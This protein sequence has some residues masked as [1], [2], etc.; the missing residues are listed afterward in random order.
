M[1]RLL[2]YIIAVFLFWPLGVFSQSVEL[3]PITVVKKTFH[4][5]DYFSQDI[6]ENIPFFSPEEI[7]DYSS[8]IELKKRSLFGIQQDVSVRGSIFEDTSVYLGDIEINDPQT[9]HFNLE[10]P[11]TS[12]DLEEIGILKNSQKIKFV[13]KKP[14]Q[15]GGIV[16][17]SFGQH[18]LWEEGLSLNFPLKDINNRFS[19]EHKTSSGGRQDTDF[20]IYNFSFHSLLEKPDKE[21]EFLFGATER[22]FGADAFYVA[23]RPHEEEHVTQRFFSLR[24]GL[25]VNAFK[26][27]NT[28]YFRRHSD[29]YILDRHDPAYYTNY[30]TTYVYG[31]QSSFDFYNDLFLSFDLEREKI[32]STNLNKHRRLRKGASIGIKDKK[33]QDLI[34][35]FEAGLNY[36][37]SWEYLEDIHLGA[38][39]CLTDDLKLR[40]SFDRIWRAPSFTELYYN[41]NTYNI[42]TQDLDI[43]KSNNFEW[44]A[45]FSPVDDC[46]LA[47][48]FFL[49]EQFDTIDWVKDN[50]SDPWRT[51]NIGDLDVYGFDFY[52]E[53]DFKE[54][55]L[56]KISI[57]YTY[58]HL[59]KDKPFTFSKYV[60]DY[61]RHKV[62]GMMGLNLCGI[63]VNCIGNFANPIDRKEY[64]TFDLKMEKKI[65]DFTLSLEGV[66]IFNKDYFEMQNI[67][68]NGR[69]YKVAVAYTF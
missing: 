48:G 1:V 69:W 14:R 53:S 12:F 35:D 60:F 24:S 47:L 20:E 45:E 26:L 2:N 49:R 13:P 11:L 59:D 52:G 5:A 9:G 17:S 43:Q 63:K 67:N 15:S 28:L 36:Y 54:N 51:R 38:A 56:D 21:L 10:I 33:I 34:F 4:G 61:S 30:H 18:A 55:L 42:G 25:G 16:S 31:L 44:M 7:V 58:L 46:S 8:A 41:D 23:T 3:E 39:Y 37:E 57:G 29:K 68:G 19:M 64:A 22:D 66:N 40:F 6:V 27:N 62:V 50:S 32:N 65:S